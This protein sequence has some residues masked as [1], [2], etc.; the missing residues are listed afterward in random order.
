LLDLWRPDFSERLPFGECSVSKFFTEK[1]SISSTVGL[2]QGEEK[3]IFDLKGTLLW[4]NPEKEDGLLGS[5]TVIVEQTERENRERE[6]LRS[7]ELRKTFLMN[8]S[9][10]LKT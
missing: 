8:L 2:W 1:K 3:R 4:E 5:L 10:G 9:K 6:I 7:G